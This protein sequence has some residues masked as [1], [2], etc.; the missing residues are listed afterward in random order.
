[1]KHTKQQSLRS[2]AWGIFNKLKEG[3]VNTVNTIQNNIN[4]ASQIASSLNYVPA[5]KPVE[6][7][8]QNI[9]SSGKQ[10]VNTQSDRRER[11]WYDDMI[12]EAEIEKQRER[13]EI[14][15]NKLIKHGT[16]ARDPN[17]W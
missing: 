17:I 6:S 2:M 7:N 10:K 5:T 11:G 15:R 3:V 4:T 12:E 14:A 9:V 13:D 1:M 16:G 8:K